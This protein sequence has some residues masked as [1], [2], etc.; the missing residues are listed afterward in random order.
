MFVRCQFVV[1]ALLDK[2]IQLFLSKRLE[3]GRYFNR[4]TFGQSHLLP[5]LL[6]FGVWGLGFGVWGLGFGVWGLGFGGWGLGAW[7]LPPDRR[8]PPRRLQGPGPTARAPGHRAQGLGPGP[9]QNPENRP[10]PPP[11]ASGHGPRSSGL[12]P[13]S[14]KPAS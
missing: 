14:W 13:K 10:L 6:G 7:G 11:G 12:G 2:H 1:Q 4:E 3:L 5:K 8:L 9:G